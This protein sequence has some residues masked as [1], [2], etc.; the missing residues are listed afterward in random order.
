MADK[1]NEIVLVAWLHC[2]EI[3]RKLTQ[4]E[5]SPN[6]EM[7]FKDFI[8]KTLPNDVDRAFIEKLLNSYKTPKTFEEK[9]LAYSIDLATGEKDFLSNDYEHTQPLINIISTLRL[10]DFSDGKTNYSKLAP[11]K[12]GAF[13]D[14]NTENTLNKTDIYSQF[15]NDFKKLA[16]RKYTEFLPSLVSLFE[17]YFWCIPVSD[18]ELQDVSLFQY[19]KMTVV[20]VASLYRY[21]EKTQ[22]LNENAFD[23]ADKKK[24]RIISGD[25]SGI[26]K[27]IFDLKTPS[28]AAKLLRAKSF[29]LLALSML[30]SEY[31]VEEF[32]LT[33]ANIITAA[34]G[35]FLILL[36]NIPDIEDCISEL[37]LKFETYFLKEFAG[38]LFLYFRMEWL[39]LQTNS[40]VETLHLV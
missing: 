5:K 35:K 37:R 18:R 40:V 33:S 10:T 26:Q 6:S 24:F 8:V 11:L 20:F 12:D 23:D 34:G 7:E 32:G 19:A 27:Y 13:L 14:Y 4:G 39:F 2:I 22:T 36:P 38:R 21:H 30:I 9:L 1:F 16:N 15:I 25:M 3:F 17:H 28:N 29:Q 31:I